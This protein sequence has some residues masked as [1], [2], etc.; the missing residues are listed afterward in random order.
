MMKQ[1]SECA[2]SVWEERDRL[3]I[4]VHADDGQTTVIDWW[5][6]AAR[7]LIEDGFVNARRLETSV[8]DYCEHL[9]VIRS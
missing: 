9:G 3:H 2:V 7:E 6:D 5:D 8:L 1:R 4:H